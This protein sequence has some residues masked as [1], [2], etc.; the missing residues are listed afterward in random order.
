MTLE[1]AADMIEWQAD[2]CAQLDS[3]LYADLLRRAA[4]DV[5]TGGPCAAA[6]EGY[7]DA[8]GPDAIALR[9]AGGVH[10]LVLTGRAPALAAYYPSA[11][12]RWT[13]AEAD[14]CWEAFRETVGGEL[15]W[16]RDWMTRPPQTN[17]VGRSNA[18]LAGLLDAVAHHPLP[19]RLLE[20][21]ASAGLNLRAE[22]FR[23]ESDGF[24]WGPPDSPVRL[25]DAWRG[26]PPAWLTQAAAAHPS[27][28]V[29]ER[30]GC[31][32]TPID[33][34]TEAGALALRSYVWPDQSARHARLS[35]ALTLAGTLPARVERTGAADFLAGVAVEPGVL[36][37]VW[38]SVMRQYVPRGEWEAVSGELERLAA[39]SSATAPFAYVSLEPRRVGGGRPFVVA[40]R[41]GAGR[42]RF[43]ATAAPHGLRLDG[44]VVQAL[45]GGVLL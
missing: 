45:L 18:L 21:G 31:D 24:A 19:V 14:A 36:T 39:A 40:T 3:P 34:L 12:G 10:A 5:R 44:V 9:L 37:V 38:H 23:Y 7:E 6:V 11:G 15:P 29:T 17:E 25:T 33:P 26:T 28:R 4:R 8:P 41:L 30:R 1:R 16:I 32:L 43:L 22:A 13:P 20:L 42:E 27:L 2:A 35:G